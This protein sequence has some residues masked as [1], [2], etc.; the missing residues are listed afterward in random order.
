MSISAKLTLPTSL[1]YGFHQADKLQNEIIDYCVRYD[2]LYLLLPDQDSDWKAIQESKLEALLKQSHTQPNA[3]TIKECEAIIKSVTC[4]LSDSK[5]LFFT[6]SSNLMLAVQD[7]E[8]QPWSRASL[9]RPTPYAYQ[10][11]RLRSNSVSRRTNS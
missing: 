7:K 2:L 3:K 8:S 1:K 10:L 5:E 4:N 6:I 9:M 11:L